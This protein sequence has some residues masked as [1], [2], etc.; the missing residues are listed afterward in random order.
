MRLARN[1]PV[2]VIEQ[3]AKKRELALLIQNLDRM[4][5]PSW[6]L[7]AWTRC[8]SRA[9]AASICDR[10]SVFMLLLVNCVF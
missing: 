2:V 10:S 8:S 7:N 1:A 4:K 6:R 3:P 9:S 5:S